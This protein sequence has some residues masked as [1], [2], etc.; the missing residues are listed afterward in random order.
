MS[1]Q[2]KVTHKNWNTFLTFFLATLARFKT[3]I[4]F[5]DHIN[6]TVTA[7]DFT[8]RRVLALFN[9]DNTCMRIPYFDLNAPNLP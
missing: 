8:T 9:E 3:W 2:L 6:H 1:A 4:F 7:Y 5:T